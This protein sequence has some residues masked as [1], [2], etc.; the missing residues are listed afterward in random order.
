MT[1]EPAPGTRP[2]PLRRRSKARIVGLVTLAW[3][4]LVLGRGGDLWWR[5]S[6]LLDGA[7]RRAANLTL[8]LA[9]YLK[10]VFDSADSS[11]KQLAIHSRRIGGVEAAPAE[12]AAMLA[13]ARAGLTGVG[14]LSVTD[15]GG[16]IRHSTIPALIGQSRADQYVIRQLATTSEDMLVAD[17]P[18]R[19]LMTRGSVML[20]LGRRLAD[21]EGGFGGTVV[22]TFLPSELRRF[23]RTVD[24]GPGGTT[25]IFHPDGAILVREPSQAD[26]IGEPS[27]DNPVFRAARSAAAPGLLRGPL[28]PGGPPLLSAYRSTVQP[29]LIV[30]VSLSQADVLADWNRAVRVS[31]ALLAVLGLAAALGLWL[32]F[33]QLEAHDAALAALQRAQRLESVAHLTGGVA[34]DFNNILMVV[35]G[36]VERLRQESLSEAA[37]HASDEI[38]TA[39]RR[40]ADLTRRLLAFAR[41]QPLQPRLVDLN[42]PLQSVAP[43]LTRLLGEDVTLR[44]APAPVPRCARL[45]AVQLETAIMNLC[46]NAR[47]AMPRGGLLTIDV[48]MVDRDRA[49]GRRHPDV[50]P[51]RYVT[52]GVSDTGVGIP[53]EHLP[54][55]FEPF[56][57]TKEIGKGTG[58]GLSSVH[59]FVTQ[60]GGHVR[61]T[62][63]VGSGTT[64]RLYFPEA[65]GM[66]APAPGPRAPEPV[67]P[68]PSAATVLLVEDDPGVRML[69]REMVEELGYRVVAA[70][71]GPTALALE[72]EHPEIDLLFTDVMLP[73]GMNGRQVAD[74]LRRRRPGL[75]VVFASG[76]P[77]DVIEE[78]GEIEA[79]WRLLGKPYSF[80][81]LADALRAALEERRP[82]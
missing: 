60:S 28:A 70:P 26:P 46:V 19:S 37:T 59:G 21:A 9:E 25:W 33:R 55:V 73:N 3:L 61:V 1:E 74:E 51:G 71:D 80:A 58:L 24:V 6:L 20:P 30:G 4:A 38:E 2:E 54:R 63:E 47:D 56:F 66:P 49:Y 65:E 8:I 76:Y 57:T 29:S 44:I 23:F 7:E 12:W 45:D 72:S 36:N 31:A 13:S 43:M 34:H 42:Q 67:A 69:A 15:A 68:V 22:A 82:G 18:F 53:A 17:T 14:S 75:P 27:T 11:L 78:R 10:Q 50:P 5:R 41:R 39:A 40:A 16:V 64:I 77:Q 48:G 81:D 32:A 79:G 52:I 62:S 35:L